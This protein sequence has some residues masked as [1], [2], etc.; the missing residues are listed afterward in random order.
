MEKRGSDNVGGE[1]TKA[2]KEATKK[3]MKDKKSLRVVV[4]EKRHK[5][6]KDHAFNMNESV[7]GFI[8]RAINETMERDGE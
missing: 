6:I 5:E 4:S 3:Y 2:Q 8:N 1:Y 7:N